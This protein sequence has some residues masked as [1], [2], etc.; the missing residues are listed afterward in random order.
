ML[1]GRPRQSFGYHHC[2]CRYRGTPF[3]RNETI[4]SDEFVCV[5]SA[6]HPL[7][8]RRIGLDQFLK[9]QHIVIAVVAGQQTLVDRPLSELSFKW[10]VG[11]S[12]PFFTPAA[13][14]AA[15]PREASASHPHENAA[16]NDFKHLTENV[17]PPVMAADR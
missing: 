9:Y 13:S 10:D 6:G 16:C 4:F 1:G 12:L 3:A 11:L 8:A 5:V 14:I 7:K 17:G 2:G 15:S